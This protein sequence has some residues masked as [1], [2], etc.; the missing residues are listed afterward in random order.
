MDRWRLRRLV[1]LMRDQRM[2]SIPTAC[3]LEQE[4][5]GVWCDY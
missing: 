2:Q 1:L 3:L 5:L 4:G